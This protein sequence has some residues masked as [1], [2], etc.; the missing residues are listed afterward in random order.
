MAR[1]PQRRP[2][3]RPHRSERRS[4]PRGPRT[5]PLSRQ[6]QRTSDNLTSAAARL[7]E[8]GKEAAEEAATVASMLT[9][10][11]AAFITRYYAQ[12]T[13]T[14]F[15]IRML[16]SER[17]HIEAAAKENG[18]TISTLADQA[19]YELLHGIYMPTEYATVAL[20]WKSMIKGDFKNLNL[21]VDGRLKTGVDL[22]MKD[23][24]FIEDLG[25][26]PG[27]AGTLIRLWL[28]ERFPMADRLDIAQAIEAYTSGTPLTDLAEQAGVDE[29]AIARMLTRS[30]IPLREKDAQLPPG[31]TR[32]LLTP[33]ETEEIVRRYREGEGTY[34]LARAFGV[35]PN[36][37]I[38]TI[39]RTG[40][41]RTSGRRTT[42]RTRL[43][44]KQE[45]QIVR[46]YRDEQVS[47][48]VLAQ[49]FGVGEPTI[50]RLLDAAGVPRR[51]RGRKQST[52]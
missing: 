46:R 48:R 1:D 34:V 20:P 23:D 16:E 36:T 43:T 17:A 30:G 44:Q 29:A 33:A 13:P 5:V 42:S 19:M 26:A 52:D 28:N 18:D 11:G 21:K 7:R 50:T 51:G 12:R 3:G 49:E 38:R 31:S 15:A 41:E 40:T 45:Q 32:R 9:P 35:A 2:A 8:Q 27:T 24:A 39:D 47:M 14:Q 4:P 37:V 25:W 22:L 10:V 6:D